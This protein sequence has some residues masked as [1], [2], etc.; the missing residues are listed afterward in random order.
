M[1]LTRHRSIVAG[2]ARCLAQHAEMVCRHYLCN[3]RRTGRY[4]Q[5]GD[6]FNTPGQSLYVHLSGS[7]AGKWYDAA[8]G[9]RG[10]LLDLIAINQHPSPFRAVLCEASRF[11][12]LPWKPKSEQEISLPA[13]VSGVPRRIF[14]A[15]RPITGTIVEAYLRHRGIGLTTDLPALRFHPTCTYKA[16]DTAPWERRPALIAAVTDLSGRISGI[17]R[18]WLDASG[19]GKA[20]ILKPRRALGSLLGNCVRFSTYGPVLLAGEGVETVLSLKSVIPG[21]PMVAAL[22]ASRLARLVLP[23]GLNRL[24]VACDADTA[25]QC[26]FAHLAGRAQAEGFEAMPLRPTY[27]DFNDDL[28][29][30]GPVALA[31]VLRPQIAPLDRHLLD[32]AARDGDPT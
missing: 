24:Y 28:R 11:L 9:E 7:R 32:P 19:A 23:R 29:T 14:A 21:M 10:D 30:L 16:H 18:T 2:V 6:V 12:A 4:W 1:S 8:T 15:A 20:P 26:A 17:E 25:G 27:G 13:H 3:G 5:V 31:A 22:S